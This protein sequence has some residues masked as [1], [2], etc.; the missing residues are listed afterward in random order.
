M[1]R[2]DRYRP[3]RGILAGEALHSAIVM[4]V[5]VN[6]LQGLQTEHKQQGQ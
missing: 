1:W 3:G 5:V 2:D 6:N 4:G